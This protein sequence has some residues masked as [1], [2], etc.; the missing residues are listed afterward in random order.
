MEVK[1]KTI[2]LQ[3]RAKK[4]EDKTAKKFLLKIPKKN[5][6]E[7]EIEKRKKESYPVQPNLKVCLQKNPNEFLILMLKVEIE[8]FLIKL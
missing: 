7:K 5:L 3:E 8:K 6:H 1:E 2:K 4:I